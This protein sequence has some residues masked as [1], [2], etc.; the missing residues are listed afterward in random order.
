MQVERARVVAVIRDIREAALAERAS[1]APAAEL[2]GRDIVEDVCARHAISVDVWVAAME[3]GGGDLRRLFE[4]AMDELVVEPP[5]PGPYDTI[6][7]ESARGAPEHAPAGF[8]RDER[9]LRDRE[10]R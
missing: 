2:A 8:E 10:Y 6:S 1:P 7:R 4:Q 5:D 9:L 3:A